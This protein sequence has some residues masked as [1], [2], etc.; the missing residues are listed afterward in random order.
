VTQVRVLFLLEGRDTPSSRLRVANYLPF[1]DRRRYQWEV[2]PIPNSILSRPALFREADRS[3][4]VLVQKKLFR[5]WE[6]AR[7][8]RKA[9]LIYDFDDMVMLPGREK[10]QVDRSPSGPRLRR[11][12]RTL[13]ASRLVIAGSDYLRGQTGDYRDRVVVIPTP[14]D[15]G[16]QPVKRIGPESDAPVL[17]WIGTK[18]NLHYLDDLSGVFRRLAERYPGMRLKVVSDAGIEP[19]GVPV[20]FKPWRLEE[21]ADDLLGFDIG[22]MPLKDDP[23][24]R[25]K[26]GFKLLQYMAAGLPVLASPVGANLEIVRQGVN[27]YLASSE[28]E[29][30]SRLAELMDSTELRREMGLAGRRIVEERYDLA[31]RAEAFARCLDQAAEAAL[32][33]NGR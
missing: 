32:K 16:R 29:W 21:E 13:A 9:I 14:V 23:W 20:D 4:L 19:E 1:L 25:G 33:G 15:A 11:F 28:S 5:P 26:C 31:G 7:L 8:A 22:L 17:G 3:D 30:E 24:T 6:I 18:G 12:E 2:R 10:Y 27:G